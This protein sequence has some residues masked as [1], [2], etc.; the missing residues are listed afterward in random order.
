MA[1]EWRPISSAPKDGTKVLV[2]SL[3]ASTG[4][5]YPYVAVWRGPS[6]FDNAQIQRG[7]TK[8]WRGYNG[9]YSSPTHW[10]PIP[11]MPPMSEAP[12]ESE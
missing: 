8:E 2:V 4:R 6:V 12:D 7:E 9:Q 10:V 3:W 11:S 5:D 1:S